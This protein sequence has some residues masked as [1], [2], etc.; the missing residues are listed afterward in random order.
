MTTDNS[1]LDSAQTSASVDTGSTNTSD[2]QTT[3]SAEVVKH[4]TEVS[5]SVENAT[6][7]PPSVDGNAAAM[8]SW[9]PNY[10]FKAFGKEHEI[11]QEFRSF[12][13]DAETEKAFRKLHEKA[14]ALE[15]LQADRDRFRTELETFKTSNEP[16]LKAVGQLNKL[17]NNKDYDNFFSGLGIKDE[18][19]FNWVSKKLDVMNM[20]PDQRAHFE[21]QQ[22]LRMQN[23]QLEHAHQEM[24]QQYQVQAVQA[25]T[26][27]LD[28]VLSRSDVGNYAQQWDQKTGEIG[29]F[30]NLIIEE[31]KAIYS[32]TGN[33]ISAEQAVNHVI[34]KFGKVI[35]SAN[36]QQVV[37]PQAQMGQAPQGLQ[38]T[39]Q[40]SQQKPPVIPHVAGRGT[41][42]VKKAP[43]TL[44]DVRALAKQF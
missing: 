36:G 27:Q 35:G 39:S 23:Y 9:Q 19:I 28:S 2:Q 30:R 8:P 21:Q 6:A 33:D 15:P 12:I 20:P 37:M 24:Q 1:S 18:E 29:S 34:Q 3:S 10:K 42:P 32:Q 7:T 11:G 17:L 43:K 14:Y 38:D 40:M 16:T 41:S 25:R 13:K 44:D 4:A 26:M 31:A 22:Q 5:K